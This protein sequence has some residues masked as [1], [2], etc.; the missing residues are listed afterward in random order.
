[1]REVV[2][3]GLLKK[4]EEAVRQYGL[5]ASG[6]HVLVAVS[7]G[8]DSVTLL[9]A[10]TRLQK[11]WQLQLHA[12]HVDHGL[13]PDSGDDA[14]FVMNFARSVGVPVT[15]TSVDVR[16]RRRG[17]ESTQQAARRL[18][19][20]VLTKTAR[21]IEARRIALGHHADD[22]AETVLLRLLRGA[23][24]TGLGGMRPLRGPFIRPLLDIR[25]A[26]IE[27]YCTENGLAVLHD[28]SNESE[29]Y[30]RNR[31]RRQLLPFLEAEYNPNITERL[32]RTA[33]L[34]R[35]DDAV[36]ESL[37]ART[38]RR[39]RR[40][41]ASGTQVGASGSQTEAGGSHLAPAAARTIALSINVVREQAE[42][43][44]RRIVRHA[45]RDVGVDL[46]LVT[47]EHTDAVVALV[48]DE[49]AGALTL[50]GAVRVERREALLLFAAETGAGGV[51]RNGAREAAG[52]A[53][54]PDGGRA[55]SPAAR[56][57][58]RARIG[59]T[60]SHVAVTLPAP[61][62]T[63]RTL[64]VP[65]RTQLSPD[66][67]VETSFGAAEAFGEDGGPVLAEAWFDWDSL[68]PPLVVRSRAD[69]DRMRPF[70]LGGTKKLQDLFVDE[71]VP[72]HVRA[73][74]PV[75]ADRDGIVW[76]PGLRSDERVA[77]GPRT[78][79]VLHVRITSL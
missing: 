27:Q 72:R 12:V 28:P 25:R 70:G 26:A 71:K 22:Q 63:E 41:A 53:A 17:G 29:G 20:A 5:L 51:S 52:D 9:H 60:A 45:L 23:G 62:P 65:G 47:Y 18:R 75:V 34:L 13:R 74:V 21:D 4:V 8:P 79:R 37:A 77:L 38:Y 68:A 78:S 67:V 14:E 2:R 54:G 3:V 46:R 64:N 6:D 15:V 1:M 50:P 10:L 58:R 7:G 31:I 56:P 36:L 42:A 61:L 33:Q 59:F 32:V 73:R 19:Y 11:A 43:L 76:V 35:A 44:R 55:A 66:I 40:A 57:V 69:G 48:D 30:A 24:T 16:A 49:G 39:A